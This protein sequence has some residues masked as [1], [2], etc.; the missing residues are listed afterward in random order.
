MY[1]D[2]HTPLAGPAKK[3]N[4]IHI[5]LPSEFARGP[6]TTATALIFVYYTYAYSWLYI[7]IYALHII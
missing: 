3:K 4:N 7:I 2:F 1:I 6:A 5:F